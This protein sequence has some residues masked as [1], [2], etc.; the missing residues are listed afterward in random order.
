MVLRRGVLFSMISILLSSFF[1]VLFWSAN[2]ARIDTTTGAVETRVTVMNHYITS[3]DIY[4][5]DATRLSTR[6]ALAAMTKRIESS[7]GIDT[8]EQ[9]V[10][11]ISSCLA[12]GKTTI[13]STAG[14][15]NCS[16]SGDSLKKRIDNFTDI[17]K[18]ELG[19]ITEYVLSSQADINVTD[20]A[21]FEIN[22]RFWMNYTVNDSFS[23]WNRTV[24]HT[25]VVSVIGLPDP[26]FK[27]HASGKVVGGYRSR[28]ITSFLRPG[29]STLTPKN[30][31]DMI[32]QQ[33][34][35]IC[36]AWQASWT[37]PSSIPL[38]TQV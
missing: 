9:M 35:P 28:N 21:P 22:V 32:T 17:G 30:V 18:Q 8:V 33:A 23:R 13:S 5:E 11:N 24:L 27:R 34:Y 19:I 20:F 1:I 7:S 25:V 12:T 14:E 4:V 6:A 16:T 10:A 3:L 2:T 26:L 31:S 36:S 37:L 38:G 29:G 15:F